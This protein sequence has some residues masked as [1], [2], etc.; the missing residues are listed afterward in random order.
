MKRGYWAGKN[1]NLEKYFWVGSTKER[2]T[3]PVLF[4]EKEAIGRLSLF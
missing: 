2:R 3:N 1:M 4:I